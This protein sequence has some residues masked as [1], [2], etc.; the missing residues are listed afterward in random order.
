MLAEKM[1][2]LVVQLGIVAIAV[3]ISFWLDKK[4]H[5]DTPSVLPYKWGF[6]IGVMGV[7]TYGI[8]AILAAAEGGGGIIFA[9]FFGLCAYS[10]YCI[11][12]REKWAWFVGTALTL[13]PAMW[14][15]NYSYAKKRIDELKIRKFR[16]LDDD[17]SLKKNK[18][19]ENVYNNKECTDTLV[20]KSRTE[21]RKEYR[22]LISGA[23]IWIL[24]VVAYVNIFDP[25]FGYGEDRAISH[26]LKVIAFPP[27][28]VWVCYLLYSKFICVG[29]K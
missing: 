23:V 21:I 4:L 11:I 18:E 20:A 13:N 1:G 27:G 12:K 14:F 6:Y 16:P 8:L 24:L 29:N 15:I 26:M 10:F 19:E 3:P 2:T 9:F 25:Y 22:I 5:E 7:I 17:V 28:L